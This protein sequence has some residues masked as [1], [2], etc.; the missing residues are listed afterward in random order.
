MLRKITSTVVICWALFV[1]GDKSAAESKPCERIQLNRP[2]NWIFSGAWSLDGNS[3]ILTDPAQSK[4]YIVSPSGAVSLRTHHRDIVSLSYIKRDPARVSFLVEDEGDGRNERLHRVDT[5]L[6]IV[7][8]VYLA[9]LRTKDGS[10]LLKVWTWDYASDWVAGFGDFKIN[11][12]KYTSAYF[13]LNLATEHLEILERVPLDNPVRELNTLGYKLLAIGSNQIVYLSGE[14]ELKFIRWGSSKAISTP[15]RLS[16]GLPNFPK[17]SGLSNLAEI[18]RAL[19]RQKRIRSLLIVD[20]RLFLLEG[21]GTS[22]TPWQ[23]IEINMESG[24]TLGSMTLPTKAPDVILIPGKRYWAVVEKATL[25]SFNLQP[26]ESVVLLD[27]SLLL[28]ISSRQAG[29]AMASCA[30]A[31]R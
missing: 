1:P 13:T 5:R 23:V 10:E 7:D 8:T 22:N 29:D 12:K 18:H 21:S 15:R 11:D 17:K 4:A 24:A 3:L 28:T 6:D 30:A 16:R 2:L 25:F 26:V 14:N 27:T 31:A 20:D 19:Y 9:G